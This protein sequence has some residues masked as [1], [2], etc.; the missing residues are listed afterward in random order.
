M[1]ARRLRLS[2]GLSLPL[3]EKVALLTHFCEK[4]PFVFVGN[5]SLTPDNNHVLSRVKE[6]FLDSGQYENKFPLTDQSDC[7]I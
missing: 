7:A 4:A 6:V 3:S 1:L 2:L 5:N